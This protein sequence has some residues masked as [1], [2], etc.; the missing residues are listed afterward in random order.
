MDVGPIP[1]SSI[2]QWAQMHGIANT[3]DIKDLVDILR[4]MESVAREFDKKDSE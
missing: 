1:W 4:D 3:D 2:V